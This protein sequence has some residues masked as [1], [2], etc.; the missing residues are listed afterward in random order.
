MERFVYVLHN[1]L[2]DPTNALNA[3][4]RLKRCV[5]AG[6]AED[7]RLRWGLIGL[8][9]LGFPCR[10]LRK[11]RR[12]IRSPDRPRIPNLLGDRDIEWSWIASQ[13]PSSPGEALDFGP[14]GSHQAL[15]AAQR[16]FNVTAVDLESVHW[17]YVHPGLRF[18]QGDILKLPLPTEHFDLVINCSTVE[19][20][21]LAGRYGVTENRPDGDLEAMARLHGLMKP[22]GLMLLTIPVGQDAVFAPFHRVYG[23]ER[24]PRLLDGYI[25]EKEAFW[26]KDQENRWVSCD[27]E[28]ALKFEASVHGGPLQNA[29]ALGCFVL[30]KPG[31]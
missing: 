1:A 18:I 30:R 6:A 31:R 17:P 23:K 2:A 4:S 11:V 21:G 3:F 9:L 28:T 7:G 25:V 22:N 20:V 24:L 13:M 10:A 27:R 15:I 8:E 12:W 14:G 26:V 19:H 5:A 29:Y 16:G